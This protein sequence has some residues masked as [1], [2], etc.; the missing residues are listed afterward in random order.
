MIVR[1]LELKFDRQEDEKVFL[2]ADAGAEVVITDYLADD[3]K[4]RDKK[5]YLSI[6]YK[7]LVS[8]D[9]NQKKILNELLDSEK[10]G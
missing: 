8:S 6:D 4:E 5:V 3:F 10:D 9:E 2:K 1:N 7:P